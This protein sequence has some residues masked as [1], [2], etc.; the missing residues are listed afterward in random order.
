MHAENDTVANDPATEAM[1]REVAGTNI[2]PVTLLSTDYLNHFNEIAM[3][4]EL[5]PDMP[6]MLEEAKIWEPKTYV[7][8][9]QQSTIADRDLAIACW[10][11]VPARFKAPFEQTIATLNLLIPQIIEHAELLMANNDPDRLQH[12]ISTGVQALHL[13]IESASGI[14]HGSDHTLDQGDIDRLIG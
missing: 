4:L 7:E 10:P 2:S 3:L 11:L 5:I 8:H 9:F 1:R 14:I 12:R 6:D 13:Y